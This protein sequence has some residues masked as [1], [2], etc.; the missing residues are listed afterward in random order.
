MKFLRVMKPEGFAVITCPDLQTV[1][2]LVVEDK[3][4]EIAFSPKDRIFIHYCAA[5]QGC[6]FS[7]DTHGASATAQTLSF[8]L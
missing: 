8:T 3:L 2:A 4:T 7:V 1:A 6:K 5:R